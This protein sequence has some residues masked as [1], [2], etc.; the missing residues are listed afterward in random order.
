M[1]QSPP[2]LCGSFFE[3]FGPYAKANGKVYDSL[4]FQNEKGG[5]ILLFL[6][7][8]SSTDDVLKWALFVRRQAGTMNFC[9]E[10]DG[11]DFGRLMD[12]HTNSS[13]KHFG[14]PGSGQPRCSAYNDVLGGSLTVRM[15]ANRELGESTIYYGESPTRSDFVFF[16]NAENS[17]IITES[18]KTG[19]KETCYFDRGNN[20]IIRKNSTWKGQPKPMLVP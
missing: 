15:W 10:S 9:L 14:M 6:F 17:W 18:K 3:I 2:M 7:K 16:I 1:A 12:I 20:V 11:T 4:T 5:Y 13:E 19:S 8:S